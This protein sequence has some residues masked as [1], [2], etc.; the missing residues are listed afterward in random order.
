MTPARRYGAALAIA[1]AAG[2]IGCNG[3]KV[4]D[5]AAASSSS[6]V[7]LLGGVTSKP[8]PVATAGEGYLLVSKARLAALKKRAAGGDAAWKALK[9]NVDAHGRTPDSD[10]TGA[11][12]VAVV[13]LVTGEPRYCASAFAFAQKAMKDDVASGSYLYYG[14]HMREAAMVLD[15]CRAHLSQAE[16]KAIADY[17]DRWTHEL[18]YDNQGSGWGLDDPGNNYFMA[19]LEGTA[20]AGYALLKEKH[21]NA[22][23]YLALLRD[24]IEGRVLPFLD[25]RGRGGDWH[26]GVNYGQRSK[27]R[28]FNAFAV[29]ESMGGPNYFEKTGF[30]VDAIYYAIHQLQPDLTSIYPGG[31][32]ARDSTMKVSP[33]DRDYLLMAVRYVRDEKARAHGKW[34]LE[35][36]VPSMS[37]GDFAW[38]QGL[39]RDFLFASPEVKA[40]PPTSLAKSHHAVGTGW[41]SVR[42]GWD[43]GATALSI[44]A[45]PV[46]DQTHAHLDVGSFTLFKRGWQ[47]LD[48]VSLSRSGLNWQA[49]AHNMVTVEGHERRFGEAGKGL[50]HFDHVPGAYAY[51]QVDASKLFRRRDDSFLLRE[52]TR[53]LVFLE[54]STLVVFD[55]VEPQSDARYHL[56][57]HVAEK[58]AQR[59]RLFTARNGEGSLSYAIVI[60]GA[61]QVAQDDDLAEGASRAFRIETAPTDGRFLTVVEVAEGDPPAL[62]ARAL[63][64]EGDV[65]GVILGDDVV[66]F[67]NAPGGA[68]RGSFSYRLPGTDRRTHTLVNLT[69]A[70]SHAVTVE[71]SGGE[72]IVSVAPGKGTEASAHGVIRVE[73]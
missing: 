40:A 37:E 26:E 30:V 31:D 63:D 19:F 22:Q 12:N 54:P 60:G 64:G 69:P 23:K 53:E 59:E 8:H 58:P 47:A 66:V 35:E 14:D 13:H 5:A 57:L 7:P 27:Q 2:S 52:Y 32:L 72:T 71:R 48:A 3:K 49:G 39:Y 56:R 9:A 73:R 61:S 68:T 15:F 28:L 70:A 1:L 43:R 65:A 36:V 50:L 24:K 18:W 44:A 38:R 55:R 25:Q 45:S 51:A 67:S 46:V 42:T 34:Y 62:S 4:P 41:V 20:F 33:L 21:E 6:A 16:R 10:R 17:L 29:I 11:E